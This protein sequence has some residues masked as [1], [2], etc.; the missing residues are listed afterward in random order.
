MITVSAFA[1]VPPFARGLVRDLR[2][3]WALEEAGIPY[4]ARLLQLTDKDTAAYRALQPFGQVPIFQDGDFV[5]FETGAIVQHIA[6]RSLALA[7]VDPQGRLRMNTWLFAALNSVEP[8]LENLLHIDLFFADEA[9][10]K[11]RRPG[12]LAFAAK[13]LEGLAAWLDGREYLEDDRF[14]AADLMM[15]TVLRI[16][17]TTDLVTSMPVLDAY[18]RRC[19]ARPAFHRALAAQAVS[20]DEALVPA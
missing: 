12:A 4:T 5:M 6:D 13:R 18:V 15:T 7:P 2:V 9:W 14:T 1:W 8:A 11:E 20:Y 16:P 19:E 17:R 3:R 10:A